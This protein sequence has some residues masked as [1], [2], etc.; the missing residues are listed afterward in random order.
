M[1][2]WLTFLS[3]QGTPSI[4]CSQCIKQKKTR[5][6]RTKIHI[7][8][9]QWV[10]LI[11]GHLVINCMN[12]DGFKSRQ[13][14]RG[15]G[16][17]AGLGITLRGKTPVSS[18]DT[19]SWYL[20]DMPVTKASRAAPGAPAMLGRTRGRP[21]PLWVPALWDCS[22]HPS[23]HPGGLLTQQWPTH[24]RM[25]E[26]LWPSGSVNVCDPRTLTPMDGLRRQG[27][28]RWVG[29]QSESLVNGI[30]ALMWDPREHPRHV[31]HVRT[32]Q[33]DSLLWTRRRVLARHQIYW[34][35]EMGFLSF[36]NS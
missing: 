29:C 22:L 7:V 20:G 23:F 14:S 11:S 8:E 25:S 18:S 2:Q 21:G 15:G 9:R 3:T 4:S 32:Q 5:K 19:P 10:A 6:K 34:C 33:E 17:E 12:L 31:H 16:R 28:G 1:M 13:I 27:L 35:L 30:S 24:A 26:C 36:Q